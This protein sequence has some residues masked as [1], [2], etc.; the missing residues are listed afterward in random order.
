MCMLIINNMKFK[1]GTVV[2]TTGINQTRQNDK[3]F[4]NEIDKCFARYCN[5]DWSDMEYD[6]DKAMNDDAIANG[7]DRIFATY[8]TSKGKIYIITEWDRSVTTILFPEEY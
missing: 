6:D 2:E 1:L 5:A 8:N 4:S 7:N 3:M